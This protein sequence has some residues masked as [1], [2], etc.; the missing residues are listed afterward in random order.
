[1]Q[2]EQFPV[3]IKPNPVLYN[4]LKSFPTKNLTYSYFVSLSSIQSHFTFRNFRGLGWAPEVQGSLPEM[5]TI[6]K[7]GIGVSHPCHPYDATW[8]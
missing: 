5:A 3:K 6:S 4:W 7:G 8:T 2:N 1:M